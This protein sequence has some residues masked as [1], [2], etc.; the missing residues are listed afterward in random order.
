MTANS[1]DPDKMPHSVA[2]YQDLQYLVISVVPR[3]RHSG[4]PAILLSMS[5]KNAPSAGLR[6]CP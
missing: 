5:L 4:I 6:A 1:V 2:S 3:A